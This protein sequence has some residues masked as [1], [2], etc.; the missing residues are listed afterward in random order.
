MLTTGYFPCFFLGEHTWMVTPVPFP[1]TAVKHPGPMVVPSGARVGY[2]RE[3][4]QKPAVH[5]TAGFLSFGSRA[6]AI[7]SK[8]R[9]NRGPRGSG[10][11]G[12]HPPRIEFRETNEA[13]A[14][15]CHGEALQRN[16]G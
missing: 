7:T 14:H 9:S 2:R 1:N 6:N 11:H 5:K 16:A 10:L 12:W 3:F 8:R 4:H 15:H 13:R